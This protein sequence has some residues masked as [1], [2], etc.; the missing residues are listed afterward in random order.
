[1]MRHASE[2]GGQ[3]AAAWGALV[4]EDGR[5]ERVIVAEQDGGAGVREE[6]AN[7]TG[8]CSPGRKHHAADALLEERIADAAAFTVRSRHGLKSGPADF[9][10]IDAANQTSVATQDTRCDHGDSEGAR[11]DG[12]SMRTV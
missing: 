6:F 1:M 11:K 12:P 4:H 3:R 7:G 10:V 8:A 2:H 9:T 5:G